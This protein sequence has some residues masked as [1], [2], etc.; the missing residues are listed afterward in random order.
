M[1]LYMLFTMEFIWLSVSTNIFT[2]RWHC[3]VYHRYLIIDKRKVCSGLVG[4]DEICG[5]DE[6]GSQINRGNTFI[7]G[8]EDEKYV[9][10]TLI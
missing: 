3:F 4:D 7:N 2:N 1:F 10:K 9:T 8:G 5:G 6:E